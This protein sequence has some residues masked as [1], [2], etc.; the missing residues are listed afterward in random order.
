[1]KKIMMTVAA[2]ALLTG[3]TT[4][5]PGGMPAPQLTFANYAPIRLNVQSSAVEEAYVNPNDPRDI[6]GQFVI[7]PAEAIKRYAEKRFQATGTGNGQFSIRIEDARVHLNE[8][9]Q[10]NKV[11]KWS[12]VGQED[13]YTLYLRLNVTP[14]PDG[15][16]RSPSTIVRMERTLVMPSS[17]S[18]EERE[19]RQVRFL[20]KLMT[21]VD[22]AIQKA[23]EET[24]GIKG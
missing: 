1:M 9:P 10:N 24:P 18:I 5:S 4:S 3:C 23:I 6:S 19:M 8:I 2:M 21:D 22:A 17:V 15:V 7:S 14:L 11:L 13:Q 16:L 12:G 20:E